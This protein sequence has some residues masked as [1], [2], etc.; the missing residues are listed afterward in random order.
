MDM[1]MDMVLHSHQDMDM[2]TSGM[3]RI[4]FCI[5]R[6]P[7]IYREGNVIK[8]LIPMGYGL[9]GSGHMMNAKSGT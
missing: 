9:Q 4:R 1:G 3:Q 8:M 6:D 2:G 7:M 5:G